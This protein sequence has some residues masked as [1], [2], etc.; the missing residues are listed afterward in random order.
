MNLRCSFLKY[1]ICFATVNVDDA[2]DDIVR[3]FRGVSDGLKRA[4]GTPP[5]S[6]VAQFADNRMSLSWNQEDTDNQ[7]LHH[8]NLERAH[9]LSD[10]DSNNEDLTSSVNSGCHS[11]NEVNDKGHTS[12]DT[13]HI[14][15][16]SG[17]DTQVSGQIQ[18]PV[19]AYSDSS[20]NSSLNTFE[21]PTGIPPEVLL[22]NLFDADHRQL[23]S[24]FF[25]LIINLLWYLTV[26]ANKC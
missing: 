22:H 2:M 3:Q 5:S 6:A 7:N 1:I 13:K 10:G 15:I 26:D 23:L 17:L 21:D 8:R 4:V 16:Y 24:L 11:D 12:N 14:E 20:N 19:R 25:L 9:S 18:K